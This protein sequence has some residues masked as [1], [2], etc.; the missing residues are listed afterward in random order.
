MDEIVR[1]IACQLV[2]SQGQATA[3]A[4]ACCRRGFEDPVLDTL[5]ETQYSMNPLL[6]TFPEN[7]CE[8]GDHTVSGRTTCVLSSLNYFIRKCFK[9]LPTALELARSRKYA[10][11]MRHFEGFGTLDGLSSEVLLV[12]QCFD[13]SEPLLPNLKTLWL[14]SVTAESAPFVLL[15]VSPGTIEIHITFQAHNHSNASVASMITILPARCPNL[16]YI[17]LHYLPR[18]PMITAV[19]SELL[20]TAN[21][22]ILRTFYVDSPLTEEAREV[23][24]KLPDLR[25]LKVVT[26]RGIPLPN[27]VLPNLTELTIEHDHDDAWLEMFRGATLGRLESVRFISKSGTN[28]RPSRSIRKG[29]THHVRPEHTINFQSKYTMLVEPKLFFSPFVRATENPQH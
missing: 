17:N 29:C 8:G 18:D 9:R 1:L 24:H 11:R 7:V 3:V 14:F 13:F 26:E 27:P 21:R 28:W 6:K 19:V 23:A 15:F 12:L 2:E 10:R 25:E 20:L 16:Q 5:W 22:D 4:L